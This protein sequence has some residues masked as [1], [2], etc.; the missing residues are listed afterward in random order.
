M[1]ARLNVVVA[2]VTLLSSGTLA[3][4]V[5]LTDPQIAHVA[6]TASKIDITAAKQ[7]LVRSENTDV[8]AFATDIVLKHEDVNKNGIALVKTLKVTPKD[9]EISRTL[10]KN[11]AF[12]TKKLSSLKNAAFDKAYLD[13]EVA[14][15]KTVEDV[16]ETQLIPS[17]SNAELKSLLQRGLKIFQDETQ[18]AKHVAAILELRKAM[19]PGHH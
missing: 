16:L 18:Q 4:G 10:G 17:A 3:Q 7:A 12:K 13:N 9:N 15:H 19:S 14:Y 11:A 5:S 6:Y 2:A 1:F 8:R